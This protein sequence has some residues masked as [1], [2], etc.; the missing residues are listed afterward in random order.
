MCVRQS[1]SIGGSGL[2][3][4]YG[5][6]DAQYKSNMSKD[7]PDSTHVQNTSKRYPKDIQRTS[8]SPKTILWTSFGYV[9][10][11][12][13]CL[14]LMKNTLALAMARDGSSGSVIRTGV[15]TEKGIERKVILGNEL[16]RFYKG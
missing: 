4:V 2:T 14:K 16:P 3:Y 9:V 12:G 11:S 8:C 10:L 1:I 13:E 6:V 5:Y 15:I 7:D